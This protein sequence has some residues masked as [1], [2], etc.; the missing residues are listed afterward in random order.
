MQICPDATAIDCHSSIV[1]ATVVIVDRMQRLVKVADEV[2]EEPERFSADW[3]EQR[4]VSDN[5]LFAFN[6]ADYA[7]APPAVALRIISA[8]TNWNIDEM[9]RRG[10]WPLWPHF[11]CP[12]RSFDHHTFCVGSAQQLLN[13][14]P[15]AGRQFSS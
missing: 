9:P 5:P 12:G 14:Q 8:T 13:L 6:L 1:T 15:C 11:V 7:I 2:D 3:C 4:A 10:F